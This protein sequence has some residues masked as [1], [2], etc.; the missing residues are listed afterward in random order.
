MVVRLA[1]ATRW[2]AARVVDRVA[3]TPTAT[4]LCFEVPGWPGHLAGQH[5]DVRLTSDDGYRAQRSYSIAAPADGERVTLTVQELRDGEVSPFLVHDLSV[6]DEL[7]LRGPL[8][9]WFVWRATQTDPVL[10]VGG[11]SGV[12]PL[13]AMV[14]ARAMAGSR[15]PFR[16]IYAVR[17]PA[18]VYYADELR[19]RVRDDHG[20]DVTILYSRA[21]PD[22]DRRPAGRITAADLQAHGWPGSLEPSV[23]LCG[24][25]PVVETVADLLTDAGHAPERIRAERYG[26]SGASAPYVVGGAA[27]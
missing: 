13:M 12:V 7:E 15:V 9:G 24:A 23:Y 8:G 11:G 22:G 14:R 16:L 19:R 10:L 3:E 20:L 1:G 17:T 27:E 18:E 26:G 5:A 4:S 2:Y 6:G 21:A 25:T